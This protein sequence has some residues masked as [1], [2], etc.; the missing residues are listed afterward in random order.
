VPRHTTDGAAGGVASNGATCAGANPAPGHQPPA[1][2]LERVVA[3]TPTRTPDARTAE[4]AAIDAAI[5][6]GKL[7][8]G[9]PKFAAP[10]DQVEVVDAAERLKA[11]PALESG[12]WRQPS[13]RKP[14][15]PPIA[16]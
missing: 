14:P 13:G 12:N 6:A 8:R 11:L 15:T 7:K 2:L 3:A 9:A 5:A 4:L 10:T 16:S 1:A